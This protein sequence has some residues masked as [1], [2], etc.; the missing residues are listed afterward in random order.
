[1]EPE[2]PKP[3]M[4]ADFMQGSDNPGML[5]PFMKDNKGT[6]VIPIDPFASHQ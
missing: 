4:L 6:G 3:S 5:P 2:Q 1:M